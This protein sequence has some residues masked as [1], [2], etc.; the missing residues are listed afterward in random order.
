MPVRTLRRAAADTAWTKSADP[1]P[2]LKVDVVGSGEVR[3][4]R[5]SAAGPR[6]LKGYYTAREA[7]H[8]LT[9]TIEGTA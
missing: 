7:H 8:A 2:A 1:L 9:H 6:L 5:A 4:G 3:F